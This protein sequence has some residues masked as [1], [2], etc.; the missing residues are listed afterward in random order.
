MIS[1]LNRLG[2]VVEK[3][4]AEAIASYCET[5]GGL[6]Q[7][8]MGGRKQRSAID[9]VPCLIQSTHEAWRQQQLMGVLFLD[10][11]G[12]FDPVNPGRLEARL[13]ELGLDGDLIRWV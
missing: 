1:L 7:G 5:I 8:Q 12:A 6:H 2:K 9:D 4:A 11:K 13:Q 10:V 3:I